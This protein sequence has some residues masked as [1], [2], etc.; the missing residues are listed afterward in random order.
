VQIAEE[1]RIR[2]GAWRQE[3]MMRV[4]DQ[5]RQRRI[6]RS[7]MVTQPFSPRAAEQEDEAHM[8]A[9]WAHMVQASVD[10]T[11]RALSAATNVAADAGRN[12]RQREATAEREKE[13]AHEY[14][15]SELCC[16]LRQSLVG[17]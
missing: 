12:T 6:A 5:E 4:E 14:L 16:L 7:A 13:L 1:E 17:V 2:A 3:E 11:E 10:S 9:R 15:V 8:M